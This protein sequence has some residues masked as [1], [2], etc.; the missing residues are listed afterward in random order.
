MLED[1]LAVFGLKELMDNITFVTDRGSNFI[2]ALMNFRVILCVAHRLNN[3]LKRT[4]FQE[5]SKKKKIIS[6]GKLLTI[7]TSSRTEITPKKMEMTTTTTRIFAQASPEFDEEDMDGEHG[8]ETEE[9]SE[10]D[11]DTDN[12]DV[13][14]TFSTIAALPVSAKTILDIIKDCKSLVKYVKKVIM[15]KAF[16]NYAHV[17]LYFR[18]I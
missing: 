4:F 2:K 6:P 16:F 14:Y 7:S 15:T 9:S 3:V 12:D 5:T 8:V 17:I 10:D 1:Q 11:S 13:D 18:R